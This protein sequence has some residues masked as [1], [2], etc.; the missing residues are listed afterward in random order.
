MTDNVGNTAKQIVREYLINKGHIDEDVYIKA[1][2][3]KLILGKG[4]IPTEDDIETQVQCRM[5]FY[6]VF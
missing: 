1:R 2:S 6:Q 5:D 3:S 4:S